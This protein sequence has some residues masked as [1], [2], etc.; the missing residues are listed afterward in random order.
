MAAS[1]GQG[2]GP[3]VVGW[4]VRRCLQT[5]ARRRSPSR[6][7]QYGSAAISRMIGVLTGLGG[8]VPTAS[9]WFLSDRH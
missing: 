8:D 5:A 9:M 7:P 6:S 3:F 2:L 1:V 4:L